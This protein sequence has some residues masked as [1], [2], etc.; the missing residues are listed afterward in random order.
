[1]D[2]VKESTAF[3]DWF[4][5]GWVSNGGKITDGGGKIAGVKELC[6]EGGGGHMFLIA[7]SAAPKDAVER[8]R[9]EF[10]AGFTG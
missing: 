2:F 9:V 4:A 3:F 10:S 1:V 7:E 8:E 5:T 6:I